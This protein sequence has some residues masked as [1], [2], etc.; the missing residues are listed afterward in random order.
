MYH[1]LFYWAQGA[2]RPLLLWI[3]PVGGLGPRARRVFMIVQHL[4]M[5]YDRI[6]NT[7]NLHDMR[8]HGELS[9]TVTETSPG[10]EKTGLIAERRASM[11]RP[12]CSTRRWTTVQV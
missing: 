2:S 7:G 10:L 4:D 8:Q 1:C 6:L 9:W 11:N 5:E 12:R 3:A